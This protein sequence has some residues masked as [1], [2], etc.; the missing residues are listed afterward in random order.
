MSDPFDEPYVSIPASI[1]VTNDSKITIKYFLKYSGPDINLPLFWGYA[2]TLIESNLKNSSG[3]NLIFTINDP[4]IKYDFDFDLDDFDT[5][6]TNLKIISYQQLQ[7][8]A[9]K[10]MPLKTNKLDDFA[11]LLN[12]NDS[13]V[14]ITDGIYEYDEL[15]YTY[16]I[17][18]NVNLLNFAAYLYQ[19]PEKWYLTEHVVGK[20]I[21]YNKHPINYLC[22]TPFINSIKY[23]FIVNYDIFQNCSNKSVRS[24]I[25]EWII[26]KWK[27]W[28]E[29]YRREFDIV[30][31]KLIGCILNEVMRSGESDW[32]NGWALQFCNSLKKL[33]QCIRPFHLNN[34]ITLHIIQCKFKDFSNNFK[35]LCNKYEKKIR[36]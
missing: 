14:I 9:D 31:R 27:N 21:I 17:M 19:H 22:V 36:I 33:S 20:E 34:N 13:V 11:H 12:N 5:H 6:D 23:T 1:R 29:Q 8:Y 32:A 18:Q 3:Q 26:N 15:L 24:S 7:K 10:H 35:I 30:F 16:D 4:T 25:N 2:M 28:S